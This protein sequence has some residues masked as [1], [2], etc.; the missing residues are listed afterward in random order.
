[1]KWNQWDGTQ[2]K[3]Q[4]T[5]LPWKNPNLPWN[6]TALP[7]KQGEGPPPEPGAA[8][9]MNFSVAANSQ[10]LAVLDDF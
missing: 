3:W 6:N 2:L 1:M 9:T 7:W 10:L 5:S 4:D 8:P